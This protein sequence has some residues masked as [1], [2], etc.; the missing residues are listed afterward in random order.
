MT[1]A[2]KLDSHQKALSLNLDSTIFG[3][4]AEIGAGQEVARWF[5]RVG[6]ASGTVAK[7]ISAYDKE[8][9]DDLYGAGTRYVSRE[10]LRAML[11]SEW[12]QLL[13]QLQASRGPTT[14]FFAFVDT[15]SARNYAGTNDSHGWVGLRFQL[16]PEEPASEVVLHVNLRDQSNVRQQEAVGFL[17]VSLV[18]AIHHA[19]GSPAE[20]L[21]SLFED[22]SLE[23]IEID[24]VEL[25]GQAFDSWNQPELHAHLVAGGYAE[26]VVFPGEGGLAPPGELLYKRAVVLAPGRFDSVEQLHADLIRDTL[27]ELPKE[28]LRESKGGLGL[29]C[30]AASPDAN[31]EPL[32][33]PEI[34]KLVDV[35]RKMGYGVLLFRAPELYR[36]SAYVNRYTKAQIHFAIGLSVLVKVLEDSYTHLAGSLLEGVARLFVQNVRLSVHPMAVEEVQKRLKASSLKGWT[37]Q[38]KNGL[39]HADQLHPE[40]PLD[41][42]YQYLLGKGYILAAKSTAG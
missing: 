28:E 11:E 12:Q 42:L 33:T 39:V 38:Q 7:T 25:A 37:W 6:G 22:L 26:A 32:A 24:C 30:L 21:A 40:Q 17:G 18:H 20:F 16:Q 5:L 29:F 36:M 14:R 1:K 41:F 35:L 13:G 10:R 31:N 4:F 8:V 23:R 27:A 19:M 34:V 15:V 9:S 3:S 2:A